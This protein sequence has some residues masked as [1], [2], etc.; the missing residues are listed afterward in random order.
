M[1]KRRIEIRR[2]ARVAT[3][4]FAA[5]LAL[6]SAA[7]ADPIAP[8]TPAAERLRFPAEVEPQAAMWLAL[9]LLCWYYWPQS[10]A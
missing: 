3:A 6:A 5:L 2:R 4:T 1:L 9:A 10:R 8:A 7:H